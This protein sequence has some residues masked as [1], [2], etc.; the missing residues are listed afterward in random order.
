MEYQWS[1]WE[2]LRGGYKLA[3]TRTRRLPRKSVPTMH[4]TVGRILTLGT[5]FGC[6]VPFAEIL[7]RTGVWPGAADPSVGLT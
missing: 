7:W 1:L 4:I 2:C 6:T 5:G 3:N